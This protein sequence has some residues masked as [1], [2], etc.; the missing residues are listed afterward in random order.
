M[1]TMVQEAESTVM[2]NRCA[3]EILSDNA[4]AG[5]SRKMCEYEADQECICEGEDCWLV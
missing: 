1:A 3:A 4:K 5:K 2:I